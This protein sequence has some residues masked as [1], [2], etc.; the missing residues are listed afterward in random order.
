M[1]DAFLFNVMSHLSRFLIIPLY[2]NTVTTKEVTNPKTKN[3]VTLRLKYHLREMFRPECNHLFSSTRQLIP[4]RVLTTG[5]ELFLLSV[6]SD[7][8]VTTTVRV[9][10]SGFSHL[11]TLIK[12]PSIIRILPGVLKTLGNEV[13]FRPL[14]FFD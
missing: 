12:G 8:F 5:F 3:H 10:Y 2:N 6:Y 14:V 1:S 13:I 4:D 11:I 9:E 7:P